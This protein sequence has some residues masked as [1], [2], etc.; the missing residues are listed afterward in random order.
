MLFVTVVMLAAG[1]VDAGT[2]GPVD[3]IVS[4][5]DPTSSAVSA[6]RQALMSSEVTDESQLYAVLTRLYFTAFEGFTALPPPGWPT[7]LAELWMSSMKRCRRLAGPAPYPVTSRIAFDCRTSLRREFWE[8]SLASKAVRTVYEVHVTTVTPALLPFVRNP[9][10]IPDGGTLFV[11]NGSSSGPTGENEFRSGKYST[12]DELESTLAFVARSV[13]S[14][15][16]ARARYVEPFVDAFGKE[17]VFS[18]KVALESTC[19]GLPTA[20]TMVGLRDANQQLL[21]ESL[22]KRWTASVVGTDLPVSCSLRVS[23]SHVGSGLSAKSGVFAKLT[24]W[25]P[26]TAVEADVWKTFTTRRTLVD[27]LSDQLL[28][29]FVTAQCAA[30]A[31][32]P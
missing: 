11:I 17:Q 32:P 22:A 4:F 15:M 12:S 21:G 9:P 26:H 29:E 1:S 16:G 7:S 19:E 30:L 3:A 14:R 8:A 6:L 25:P 24:C 10:K 18:D 20:L 5:G 2:A 31:A 13:V 28:R 27:L 23:A